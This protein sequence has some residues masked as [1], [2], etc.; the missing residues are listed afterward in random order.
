MICVKARVIAVVLLILAA[1]GG[2]AVWAATQSTDTVTTITGCVT[3]N[4]QLRGIASYS[5]T[6]ATCRAGETAVVLSSGDITGIDTP[7][8]GGLTGGTASGAA[9][10]ALQPSFA[11]PQGCASGSVIRYSSALQYWTCGSTFEP[12]AYD[13]FRQSVPFTISAVGVFPGNKVLTLQVPTGKYTVSVYLNV[14]KPD[15]AGV[16]R[17]N[18]F[19]APPDASG[20]VLLSQSLLTASVMSGT[21]V[22]SLPSGGT[23]S[24]WCRQLTGATGAF[25]ILSVGEI[26]ASSVQDFSVMEDTSS[27]QYGG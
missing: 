13:V 14:Q 2:T 19:P 7:A 9:S 5:G 23:I 25:P 21:G 15:G 3:S 1:G 16:L 11:L 4:G 24:T 18:T 22:E 10:L 20:N 8:A 27:D 17:C 6:L 26:V 12:R